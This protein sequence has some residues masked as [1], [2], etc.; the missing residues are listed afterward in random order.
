CTGA[1]TPD[2][3]PIGKPIANTRIYLL[4]AHRQPVPLGVAGEIYIGGVQVARGYLNRPELTVERFLRDPFSDLVNARMYRTGD[5]GRYLPD[6]NIDYLGRNDDQVK[7]RGFRIEPGE[8]EGRLAQHEV[9]KEA[10]VLAREDVPGEK[11]LVAYFTHHAPE[12][13]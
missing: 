3:T 12:A 9:V 10:V 5:L 11:R 4:D 13:F 1:D 8:I 2:S 6:G 7:I